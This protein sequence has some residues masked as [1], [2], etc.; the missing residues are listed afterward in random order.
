M[1]SIDEIKRS[2]CEAFMNDE[3]LARVYGFRQGDA[4]SNNFSTVSVENLL[5]YVVAVG[6][7]SLEA[8]FDIHKREVQQTVE[9]MSV[10]RPR[11][12]RDKMLSFL[13]GH[14]LVEDSDVYDTSDMTEAELDK[15]RVV[16][17]AA[18]TESETASLLT[19]KVAGVGSGGELCPLDQET[20]QQLRAYI[21]EI[22]DAGV[23]VALVNKEPDLFYCTIDIYYNALLTDAQVK[24]QAMKAI[25]TYISNLP[26]NGE[27][28]N[29]GLVDALQQVDGIVLA[30][31]KDSGVMVDGETTRTTIDARYTPASGYMKADNITLNMRAYK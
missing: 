14:T 26:F 30:E 21:S 8:L 7:H 12:Y 10:H 17:Y 6:I 22:K 19:L 18:A 5:L 24:Q 11:W 23:R 20:E 28:T 4:W 2:M 31:L 29:M 9:N 1:R 27:Y 13:K 25:E 15:A 3:T 16:K